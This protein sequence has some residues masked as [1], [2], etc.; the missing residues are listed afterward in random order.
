MGKSW[1][2]PYGRICY[3]VLKHISEDVRFGWKWI[4]LLDPSGPREPVEMS[5]MGE[6]NEE[7]GDDDE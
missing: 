4:T 3:K 7:R 2:V 6:G 5:D 1:K